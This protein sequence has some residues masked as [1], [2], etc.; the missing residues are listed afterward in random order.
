LPEKFVFI[1]FQYSLDTQVLI[2]SP[3]V[4]SMESFLDYCYAAI[5]SVDS[6]LQVV[7]KEH[8]DDFGRKNYHYLRKTRFKNRY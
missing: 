6:S 7:V 8:P 2:N 3:L 5:K 1:P 4:S